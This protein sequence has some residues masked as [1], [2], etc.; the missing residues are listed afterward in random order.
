MKTGSS[1]HSE[2]E[3]IKRLQGVLRQSRDRMAGGGPD[4]SLVKEAR[5][6]AADLAQRV[7]ASPGHWGLTKVP[8]PLR[9]DAAADAFVAMLFEVPEFR[10][11]SNVSEWYAR[12]VETRSIRLTALAEEEAAERQRADELST[13]VTFAEPEAG[14][15]SALSVFGA[16]GGFW[17]RFE[18]EFPR[19]AFV[20]RLRYML[21]RSTDEMAAM[22]E[23]PSARAITMRLGRARERLEAFCE[24]SGMDQ[25]QVGVVMEQFSEEP[26]L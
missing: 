2:E 26:S 22:L 15:E 21:K 18:A 11:R 8:E 25:R 16:G 3:I 9:D 4:E 5:A 20:L 7:L 24:Q 10:A 17:E 14:G 19:D 6:L 13:P 12:T 1:Y 23:A